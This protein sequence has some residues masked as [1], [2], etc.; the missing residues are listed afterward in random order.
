ML[1]FKSACMTLLWCNKELSRSQCAPPILTI[2]FKLKAIFIVKVICSVNQS[3]LKMGIA[4]S[5]LLH[6][7][8]ILYTNAF[9]DL[10]RSNNNKDDKSH[11]SLVKTRKATPVE[12][13]KHKP[14]EYPLFVSANV[15]TM[16]NR[17]PRTKIDSRVVEISLSYCKNSCPRISNLFEMPCS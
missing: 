4:P 12:Q 10:V 11:L 6:K 1:H 7:L 13:T 14:D 15:L 5:R 2:K 9:G 16:K 8:R 17:I 3:F